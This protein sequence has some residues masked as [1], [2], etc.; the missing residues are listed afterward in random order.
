M[1]SWKG[2]KKKLTD[3]TFFQQDLKMNW[4]FVGQFF[5][6]TW[7]AFFLDTLIMMLQPSF[8]IEKLMNKATNNEH[9]GVRM[10]HAH[11]CMH[12]M[13]SLNSW[14]ST[15]I[16]FNSWESLHFHFEGPK[17]PLFKKLFQWRLRKRKN[18]PKFH[19][20]H[21]WL[22]VERKNLLDKSWN[23]QVSHPFIY[24]KNNT[25]TKSNILSSSKYA[26]NLWWNPPCDDEISISRASS[27]EL[28]YPSAIGLVFWR[29]VRSGA[30][31]GIAN[32][33]G[34]AVGCFCRKKTILPNQVDMLHIG[35]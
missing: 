1:D 21:F 15:K 8:G 20:K 32:A 17:N 35:V 27:A 10:Q 2:T 13:G 11:P 30:T 22:W 24:S 33:M 5:Q 34:W 29:A 31:G 18:H 16:I 3:S 23:S 25:N 4:I 14:V 26:M 9:H 12:P 6:W 28:A 19:Q 7:D